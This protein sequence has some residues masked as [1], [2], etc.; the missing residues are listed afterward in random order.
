MEKKYEFTNFSI[1]Y[2]G[3]R[4]HR[5]R[6]L[7]DCGG[8]IKGALG[9]FIES[10]SNLSHDGDCWVTDFA[11]VYGDAKVS[12]NAKIFQNAR[13][14]D[15][16]WVAGNSLIAGSAKVYGHAK[17]YENAK[18]MENAQIFG[19]AF[20]TDYAAITDYAVVCDMA[21][22]SDYAV[23]KDR[24]IIGYRAHVRGYETIIDGDTFLQDDELIERGVMSKNTLEEQIRC[25]TGLAPFNGSVIAYKI[26]APDLT[27]FYDG[28]FKYEIGEWA[29]VKNPEES[30][31]VCA[32]GLHF[33]N[34]T[35]WDRHCWYL[36]YKGVY[37]IARINLED[38]ITVQKGK[39][40][41]RKA[42]VLGVYDKDSN[43]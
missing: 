10:E 19:A 5:I 38:I 13:V 32:S 8:F 40:R 25:Q 17:V 28:N 15:N 18:I 24:A 27:S 12:G 9:G 20:V 6:L 39:I 36:G 37:L 34:A 11:Y 26:V 43:N 29:I 3:R 41:C 16:A 23:I 22:V 33:S 14:F 4:L 1:M 35:Y 2:K 21:E 31:E 30:D 42:F 7:R